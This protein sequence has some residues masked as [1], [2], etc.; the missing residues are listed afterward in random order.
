MLKPS[1]RLTS[2]VSF[3]IRLNPELSAVKLKCYLYILNIHYLI[4]YNEL[5]FPDKMYI[6]LFKISFSQCDDFIDDWD[7]KNYFNDT[8]VYHIYENQEYICC[9]DY[10]ETEDKDLIY[11]CKLINEGLKNINSLTLWAHIINKI[12]KPKTVNLQEIDWKVCK[13]VHEDIINK[14]GKII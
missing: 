10:K 8:L 12:L 4:Q 11:T 9:T 1:N 14:T 6:G 5:A 2:I 13:K 3:L 7:I